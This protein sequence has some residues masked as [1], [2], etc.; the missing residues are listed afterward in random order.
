MK[1]H[2]ALIALLSITFIVAAETAAPAMEQPDNLLLRAAGIALVVVMIWTFLYKALYPFLLRHYPD[3]VCK[4]IFWQLFLLYSLTWLF[5]SFYLVLD[6]GFYWGWL[7]WA[8]VFL[9]AWWL[10]SGVVFLMR[11]PA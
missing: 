7:P 10:I 5:V 11:R 9:G 4:T 1:S 2:F 3:G 8:A 6:V